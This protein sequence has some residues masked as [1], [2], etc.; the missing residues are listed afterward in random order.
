MIEKN[1]R[2]SKCR[3]CGKLITMKYRFCVR[4]G[5]Y[6]HLSCYYEWFSKKMESWKKLEKEFKKNKYK[7][8]MILE[9]LN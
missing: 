4:Q 3:K 5:I 6:Y 9:K 2:K 8:Q 1:I 7:R